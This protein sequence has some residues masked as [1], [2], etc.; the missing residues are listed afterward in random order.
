M[1]ESTKNE[2]PQERA[3][4]YL[5]D[6][7]GSTTGHYKAGEVKT[8]LHPIPK[9]PASR[10]HSE[11]VSGEEG[12]RSTVSLDSVRRGDVFIASAVGGKHR[13]WVVLRVQGD[14]V[15]ATCLSSSTQVDGA[16]ISEC[17]YWPDC[18]IGGAIATFPMDQATREVTRR[19]TA[20]GQLNDVEQGFIARI[21]P[22]RITKVSQIKLVEKSA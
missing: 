17:R 16:L 20:K 9:I 19:F 4:R 1:T 18:F 7:D 6:I 2:T 13:P 10:N 8:L 3:L 11:V 12:C 14:S 15:L 22:K 21:S 5:N